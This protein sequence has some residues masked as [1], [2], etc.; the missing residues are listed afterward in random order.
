L[1]KEVEMLI[2]QGKLEKFIVKDKGVRNC[3][4]DDPQEKEEPRRKLTTLEIL[5]GLHLDE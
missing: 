3:L 2:Q 4:W 1:K 5:K